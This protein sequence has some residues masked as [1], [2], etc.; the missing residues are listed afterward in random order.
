MPRPSTRAPFVARA[1]E[2]DVL[3]AAVERAR[4]GEPGVVLVGADAGVG[5][6]RLLT[7]AAELAAGTGATVVW[8]HCVDLGE[9]GLPYLPF[10]EAL[11]TLRAQHPAVD[12]TVAARPALARLLDAG[13]PADDEQ[14]QGERLQLFESVAAAIAAS[15]TPEAPLVLVV[16]DLHWADPSCRAVLRFAVARLRA[17]HVLVVASY[18]ADDL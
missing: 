4:R 2:L 8:S 16:E 3:A 6:T 13:T 7:R 11:T 18:R 15:G 5:K 17:E 10:S 1:A 9:V 14:S 12:E